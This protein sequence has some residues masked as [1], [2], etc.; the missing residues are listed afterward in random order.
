[1]MKNIGQILDY[2]AHHDKT[3]QNIDAFDPRRPSLH[4]CGVWDLKE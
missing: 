4:L 1:M 2:H 3:T